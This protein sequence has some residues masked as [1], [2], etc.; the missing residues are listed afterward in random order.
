MPRDGILSIQ[1][2][3]PGISRVP[4][5]RWKLLVK[6]YSGH[7]S[8]GTIIIIESSYNNYKGGILARVKVY[9]LFCYQNFDLG[10]KRGVTIKCLLRL[11]PTHIC[12]QIGI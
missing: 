7:D 11:N 3:S 6:L 9:R 5:F 12:S 10:N 8:V 2:S 4:Q 1:W